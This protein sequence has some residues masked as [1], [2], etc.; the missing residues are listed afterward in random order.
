MR[1][2]GVRL[3][4]VWLTPSHLAF[5][6]G[7]VQNAMTADTLTK[8]GGQVKESRGLC[9]DALD[10]LVYARVE[11]VRVGRRAHVAA[12]GSGRRRSGEDTYVHADVVIYERGRASFA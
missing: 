9:D 12:A 4:T 5:L 8:Y 10:T 3:S 1:M 7:H 2:D 11:G 6:S